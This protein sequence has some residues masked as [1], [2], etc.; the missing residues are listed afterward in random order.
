MDLKKGALLVPQRAVSEL[1]GQFQV[2]VVG[3]D[4]KVEIKAVETGPRVGSLWVIEKGLAPGDRIIVEGA[5]K[6][7]PGMEVNPK[8]VPAEALPAAATAKPAE[9]AK[10]N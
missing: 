9:A 4:N 5:S 3:S 2:A 1:Q 6:V 8:A 7:Q 10:G